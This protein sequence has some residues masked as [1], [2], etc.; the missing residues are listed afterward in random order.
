V[1][2]IMPLI[3]ASFWA[4]LTAS[5][6]ASLSLERQ[7]DLPI[8]GRSAAEAP[9]KSCSACDD[10]NS[11]RGMFA[12]VMDCQNELDLYIQDKDWRKIDTWTEKAM[13]HCL[14]TL[15]SSL[16]TFRP[17]SFLRSELPV[18]TLNVWSHNRPQH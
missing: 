14:T 4:I 15:T 18:V 8:E 13:P 12:V 2:V 5:L 1:R 10:F 3:R 17:T 9:A 16:G 6:V 7:G 11:D